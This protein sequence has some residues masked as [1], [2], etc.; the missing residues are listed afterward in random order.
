MK[1][2]H[3][4]K[5]VELDL[6]LLSHIFSFL[7]KPCGLWSV[8]IVCRAFR[9][10][11]NA[12]VSRLHVQGR[13][14]LHNAC[15]CEMICD[16]SADL[17]SEMH[18]QHQ[19]AGSEA[20]RLPHCRCVGGVQLAD[21]CYGP[22]FLAH[23]TEAT[24][25]PHSSAH[26]EPARSREP[27]ADG[28]CPVPVPAQVDVALAHM[29]R[30]QDIAIHVNLPPNPARYLKA[31]TNLSASLL[32]P[33]DLS[34]LADVRS[35]KSLW[36][37]SRELVPAVCTSAFSHLRKL[38]VSVM[39]EQLPHMSALT[40]LT[41]LH[42]VLHG[43]GTPRLHPLE[44]LTGLKT[45]V[46]SASVTEGNNP[47][48]SSG[49]TFLGALTGL[50]RLQCFHLHYLMTS[51]SELVALTALTRLR[52]LQLG[53]IR[54]GHP[55]SQE[56]C[57]IP[58]ELAF[59]ETATGLETLNCYIA[60]AY[61]EELSTSTRAT[62]RGALSR[63]SCLRD[64]DVRLAFQH[65]DTYLPLELFCCAPGLSNLMYTWDGIIGALEPP[66]QGLFSGLRHLRSLQL[67][68]LDPSGMPQLISAM[69][70]GIDPPQLTRL[71]LV[72]DVLSP[73]IM[74]SI[75]RF[76]Q[77]RD[78]HVYAAEASTPALLQMYY[79]TN[80]TWLELS[81]DNDE[82]GHFLDDNWE[83]LQKQIREA[84][85]AHISRQRLAFGWPPL[86]VR[87]SRYW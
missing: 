27:C 50:T 85:S 9:A 33:S 30:L 37:S 51:T 77:L 72:L 45:L 55:S 38:H 52:M 74:E 71:D 82:L 86:R 83:V 39:V 2:L 69:L 64:L 73:Q 19:D 47:N 58:R 66:S 4:L 49:W 3:R 13:V 36:F 48:R 67:D 53:Q 29:P 1:L 54:Q 84:V 34:G 81:A 75:L 21:A 43:P 40:F 57:K 7:E 65:T 11:A 23:V 62:V 32:A 24:I 5:I 79:L 76:P 25:E 60:T 18:K 16:V 56:G 42:F 68:R 70:D 10:A 6:E 78:L 80:L 35:V 8:R 26:V 12:S 31:V 41:Y 14:L 15:M 22:V 87:V 44:A 63:L 20:L 46:M 59:L 17:L 61:L 28:S